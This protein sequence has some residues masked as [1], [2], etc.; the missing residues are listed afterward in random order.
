MKMFEHLRSNALIYDAHSKFVDNRCDLTDDEPQ[1]VVQCTSFAPSQDE[2]DPFI[3]HK[4]TLQH[5]A[6]RRRHSPAG[7]QR[8]SLNKRAQ[9]QYLH[10]PLFFNIEL[11]KDNDEGKVGR[12][13]RAG[14]PADA[15]GLH[16]SALPRVQRLRRAATADCCCRLECVKSSGPGCRVAASRRWTGSMFG[17]TLTNTRRYDTPPVRWINH[18]LGFLCSCVCVCCDDGFRGC[19]MRRHPSEM[20]VY[21]RTRSR[22]SRVR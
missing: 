16:S 5:G 6:S 11:R 13:E 14:R 18:L 3:Q 19:S 17:A 21:F 7:V 12:V 1:S 20:L 8:N 10:R 9:N 15:T 2:H 22:T 4:E